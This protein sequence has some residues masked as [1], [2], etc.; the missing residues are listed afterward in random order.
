MTSLTETIT[1]NFFESGT[2]TITTK[3]VTITA[4]TQT[5]VHGDIDPSLTYTSSPAV[6]DNLSNGDTVI[7][8]GSLTR[9]LGENVGTYPIG[10]GTLTNTNFDITFTPA[11][12]TITKL[13]VVIT[14]T[15][16]QSKN[17]WGGR[18]TRLLTLRHQ[19]FK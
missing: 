9:T 3:A 12:L 18:S 1:Q 14:P 7:F 5:K 16:S 6:G 13:P 2:L 19:C 10:I 11:D 15:A 4:D 17:L 8:T